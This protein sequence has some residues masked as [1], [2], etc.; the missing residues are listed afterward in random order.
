MDA[1][2]QALPPLSLTPHF[3]REPRSPGCFL[4]LLIKDRRL[5]WGD[6]AGSWNLPLFEDGGA[7]RA[8]WN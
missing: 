4:P 5:L 8:G 3:L 6:R 1:G 7:G 2:I